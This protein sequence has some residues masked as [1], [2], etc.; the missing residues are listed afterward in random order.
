MIALLKGM[1]ST[2]ELDRVILD[3]HGVGY[4]VSVP[5]R[6]AA[7]LQEG[8]D[9]VL[10]I[11]ENIREDAYELY[12][13][14]TVAERG[15]YLRLVTVNGVGPKMAHGILSVYDVEALSGFIDGEDVARLT[16][17]SGVGK[18]TAQRIILE[19]KGKLVQTGSLASATQ[20]DPAHQALMQL[21]Y[22]R[23]QAVRALQGVDVAGD[24]GT[25]VKA[26]LKEL[27][28]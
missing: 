1:V 12:G 7:S 15:L 14:L 10:Y 22:T 3:V 27:G 8:E 13:F 9:V 6:D 4:E 19:L 24:T 11:A 28:R 17:V 25:R 26:A 21:G 18:K 5:A 2:R 20:D 23:E 16:Q